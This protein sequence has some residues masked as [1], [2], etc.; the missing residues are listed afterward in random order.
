M[1]VCLVT[2]FVPNG[3]TYRSADAY[4]ALGEQL[5][6]VPLPT[7][8][9]YNT[10]DELWLTKYVRSLP[11]TPT[12]SVGELPE[13]D[14]LAYHCITH[15]KTAWLAQAVWEY[16]EFD[17]YA[18]VDYGVFQL[19]GMTAQVLVD[20][21]EKLDDK[22]IYFPGWWDQGPVT[23]D[24]CNW[25]FCGTAFAVPKNLVCQLDFEVREVA[26]MNIFANRHVEWEVNTWGRWEKGTTLPVHWYRGQHMANMFSNFERPL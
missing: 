15:Q 11:F 10:I 21:A 24:V 20:W 3:N 17:I 14:T 18:W 16:P 19:P 23:T 12:H 7:A 22:H 26:R 1:K 25:R 8:A 9:Y 13:K 2:G 5:A 4:V 6:A